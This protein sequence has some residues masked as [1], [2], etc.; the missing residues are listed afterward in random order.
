MEAKIAILHNE[1]EKFVEEK[2]GFSV[3]IETNNK[4]I[5]FDVSYSKDIIVNSE[6][7]GIIL[8]NIDY[9]VLS[10][11]HIDHTEGL[12]FI[13]LSKI[14]NLLAHPD[15]FQKRYFKGEGFIGIPL[16]LEYIKRKTNVILSR[17]PYWIEKDKIVFLGQIP[18]KIEFDGKEPVG[19]LENGEED[20]V[21]DDS[22]IAIK[23]NRGLIIVSGCSHSGI[24]NIIEYAKEVCDENKVYG[25]LGGFHL[26]NKEVTDKT[27]EYF[28]K[29]NIKQIYPM[30]CLNDYA[31]SEFEKIGGKRVKTLQEI[32]LS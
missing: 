22:A 8:E 1:L 9:L 32:K 27:I 12:R 15:C 11:G 13:E 10:H 30:H 18:R 20:F 26:F 5:L 24:C 14:K 25:V 23:T 31:F 4:K 6:K 3:L 16:N 28:K 19:Y 21:L 2:S 29:Q 7:A 17:K